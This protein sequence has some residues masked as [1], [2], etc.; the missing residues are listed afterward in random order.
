MLWL[1][2][3]VPLFHICFLFVSPFNIMSVQVTEEA[4]KIKYALLSKYISCS[5]GFR[6]AI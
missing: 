6:P 1:P 2:L 5:Y 3:I 4:T